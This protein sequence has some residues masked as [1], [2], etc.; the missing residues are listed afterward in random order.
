MRV[1]DTNNE[2]ALFLRQVGGVAIGLFSH[3]CM[4]EDFL[5]ALYAMRS[6]QQAFGRSTSKSL[7]NQRCGLYL[8]G[9][10]ARNDRE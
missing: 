9:N 10:S 5:N 4:G 7:D 8:T 6:A 1:M 3:V 2:L